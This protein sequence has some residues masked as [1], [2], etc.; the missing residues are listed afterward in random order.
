MLGVDNLELLAQN[1]GADSQPVLDSAQFYIDENDSLL[2]LSIS[3][4]IMILYTN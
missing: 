1:F 4:I 2:Y 3:G